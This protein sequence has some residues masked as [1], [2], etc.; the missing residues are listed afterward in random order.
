MYIWECLLLEKIIT[1][2]VTDDWSFYKDGENDYEKNLFSQS[3]QSYS[4]KKVVYNTDIG[5]SVE[6]F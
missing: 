1:T 2:V 4:K 5:P 3:P 6:H